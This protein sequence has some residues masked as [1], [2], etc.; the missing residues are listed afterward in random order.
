[1]IAGMIRSVSRRRFGSLLCGI[2][3][4]TQR[5]QAQEFSEIILRR[6]RDLRG[7]QYGRGKLQTEGNNR[8]QITRRGPSSAH[9]RRP[10]RIRENLTSLPFRHPPNI[11]IAIKL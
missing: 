6:G 11:G 8:E 3:A 4:E 5:V 9:F 10:P 2:A 7:E 1:M